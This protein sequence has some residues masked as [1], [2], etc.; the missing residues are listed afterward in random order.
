MGLVDWLTLLTASRRIG[1]DRRDSSLEL[2]LTTGL[3]PLEVTDGNAKALATQFKPLRRTVLVLFIAMILGGIVSRSWNKSAAISFGMIW[4]VLIVLC[5]KHPKSRVLKAM[6]LALN[7]GRPTH[8]VFKLRQGKWTWFWMFFNFR[9]IFNHGFGGGMASFPTG[10]VMESIFIWIMFVVALISFFV[11]KVMSDADE[12]QT[13][14]RLVSDMRAIAAD[15]LPDPNDPA[16]K[17]WDGIE[18]LKQ[19]DLPIEFRNADSLRV[20]S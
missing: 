11:A 5:L 3:T 13:R 7:T 17:K 20:P 1:S 4:G 8:S 6:W 12:S 9:N 15:P 2:L 18:R 19:R 10:S 14:I 16:F